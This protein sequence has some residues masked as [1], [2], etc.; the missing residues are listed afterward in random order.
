MHNALYLA[1]VISAVAT[2][3]MTAI[4]TVIAKLLREIRTNIKRF[5]GEHLYLLRVADWSKVNLGTV[6]EH[7]KI[8]PTEPPP[9]NPLKIGR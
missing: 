7:L 4:L 3:L 9:E 8:M 5:M 6:M 1:A 2:V